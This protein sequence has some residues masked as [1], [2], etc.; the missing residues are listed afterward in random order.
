MQLISEKSLCIIFYLF[1]IVIIFIAK[2]LK[3]LDV[4]MK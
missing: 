1:I 3:L 2:E 4:S